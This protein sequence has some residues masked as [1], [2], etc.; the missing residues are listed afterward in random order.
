[1]S[2]ILFLIVLAVLVLA[3]ELGHFLV[4]KY[5]GVK[6]DEFGF[7]FPPKLFSVKRGETVYSINAIPFGGFVNMEGEDGTVDPQKFPRSFASKSALSK[8]FII[9]AG[10]VFNLIL[11]WFLIA[12]NLGIG[13]PTQTE[14]VPES[15]R[16]NITKEIIITQIASES[17][18]SLAGIKTGDKILG[19]ASVE[20]F[21]RFVKIHQG[22]DVKIYY[23]RDGKKNW[24]VVNARKNP[25][26]GQGALGV[27]LEES[28]FLKYPWYKT[29]LKSLVITSSFTW[30]TVKGLYGFIA[31]AIS[32]AGGGFSEVVGPVGIVTMTGAVAKL[33]FSYLLGFTALLSINLAILNILPFP[34]LDGGRLLFI[35]IEKIRKKP[36]NQKAVGWAHS[37]GFGLLIV[38]MLAVTYKDIARL[39]R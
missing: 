1:M 29:P 12:V 17:P 34:A 26:S 31:G 39:I 23:N 30:L 20:D 14:I 13:M 9:V 35:I 2:I 18:A 7:G 16:Q 8:T 4:A 37:I 3:H 27:S 6:V 33:S 19:Y 5:A 11:A 22:E 36:L 21:Q 32:G 10:V 38:L 15:E 24:V 25:P 28:V